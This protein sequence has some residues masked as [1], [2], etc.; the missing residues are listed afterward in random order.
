MKKC[1]TIFSLFF[2]LSSTFLFCQKSTYLKIEDRYV[3]KEYR[4]P[5]RDGKK[6][7]TS[8]YIPRDSSKTYPI[9]LLRTPYRVAPY[10]EEA[11]KEKLGPSEAFSEEGFIF[12]YQ[13]VRGRFM[14]EG[15][16]VNVRPYLAQKNS[17]QEIDEST[18]A[19]DTIDWLLK[20]VS[21]NNGRVGMWGISYPGFY[22]AM[23]LINAHPA[24]K[25]VS[26]QA[27]IADWFIDDDMHHNGA[28]SLN[29]AFNFFST[30]G[31]VR[32]SLTRHWPKRFKH[33]TPDG[34]RFFLNMGPLANANKKYFHG[35]IPFWNL[36]MQH[37]SYDAFWQARNILPHLKNIKPAVLLVGGWYDA[38]DLYGT[39]HIYQKIEKENPG[40]DSR[41]VMGPWFHGGWARSDGDTLGDIGFGSKTSLYYRNQ[42]E[43][44]FF[45]YYLKDKGELNLPEAQCFDSGL[46]V[47]KSF[48]Q[49]PPAEAKEKSLYLGPSYTLSFGAPANTS[50]SFDEYQSDPQHPVPYINKITNTWERVY[51]TADQRFASTRPDVLVY[52]TEPLDREITMAG[53]LQASLFVS[54]S[55]TDA[56]WIVKLIDV[57]PDSAKDKRTN[58]CGIRMGGYQRLIR[59]E[60]MRAKFR[61]SFSKPQAMVPGKIS[62]LSFSLQDIFHTFKK[63]HRIMVQIQSSWFPLFD[64]NPQKFVDIY[65]AEA[66]DFQKARQRLYFS[67]KHPSR[68]VFK[69]LER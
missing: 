62:A 47:W 23:A 11:Y 40:N 7:F 41:L 9:L 56:D 14:S 53:P 64:R 6:L 50:D 29:M 3:K 57:Y 35:Q 15:K 32:D 38:E 68:I 66:Q 16:Y 34:Y 52:Q 21:A 28:F 17:L 19:Y 25:A 59:G 65:S 49:W 63:G 54:T 20:N 13:D 31:K 30:F 69:V 24:L 37:G 42:I 60:I 36:A 48:E 46:N 10:G 39:L 8:V 26:P 55:G 51:M 12:V 5:M 61:N 2:L 43:L 58:P 33:G 45:N 1:F 18:D 22:A 44:P 4:I 27:P 67:K